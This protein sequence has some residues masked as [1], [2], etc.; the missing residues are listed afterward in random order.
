VACG[1]V[2][3]EIED[4]DAVP[5]NLMSKNFVRRA[6]D[7]ECRHGIA[8]V[9]EARAFGQWLDEDAAEALDGAGGSPVA[10]VTPTK[11]VPA[12]VSAIAGDDDDETDD[13][14]EQSEGEEGDDIS[15]VCTALCVAC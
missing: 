6:C 2:C 8:Q 11:S 9:L 4:R 7:R 3:V 14:D 15:Q 1:R 10:A 5:K 12:R 13:V